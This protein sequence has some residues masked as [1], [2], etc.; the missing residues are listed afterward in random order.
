M[1]KRVTPAFRT[2]ATASTILPFAFAKTMLVME[3][4]QGSHDKLESSTDGPPS[5]SFVIFGKGVPG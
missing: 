4:R 2:T 3:I 5:D 1:T